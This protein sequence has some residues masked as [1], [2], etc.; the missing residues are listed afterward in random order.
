[1]K[2]TVEREKILIKCTLHGAT[3]PI[4]PYRPLVYGRVYSNSLQMTVTGR[5]FF[6]R[7]LAPR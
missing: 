6:V 4:T 2:R 7:L 3:T 5:V 1:M